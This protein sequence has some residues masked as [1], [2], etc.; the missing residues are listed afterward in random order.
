MVKIIDADS[1]FKGNFTNVFEG[2][3]EPFA[4]FIDK[5]AEEVQRNIEKR[6]PGSFDKAA[7]F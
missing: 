2:I 6:D 7:H 5:L 4:Q 3:S 1:T